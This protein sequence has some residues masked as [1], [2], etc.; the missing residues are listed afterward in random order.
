VSRFAIGFGRRRFLAHG[1]KAPGFFV[2]NP[3]NVYPLE[4][5]GEHIPNRNSCVRLTSERDAVGMPKLSI[6][7]RYSQQDIDGIL[8]CHEVW[9]DYLKRSRCGHLEYM[10]QDP[11]SLVWSRIGGGFH[12]LG[13]TRMAARSEEGVVDKHLAVH[14]MSNLFVAT[15]SAFLT[16]GQANPTFMIVAFALRLA[17]RLK[18][19]LPEI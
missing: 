6:N 5:Q 14:G 19:V 15:S 9:D 4:F 3:Q 13:T 10:S 2:Y 17:D 16:S 8:R 12:Q 11:A 18:S 7:L 1:A